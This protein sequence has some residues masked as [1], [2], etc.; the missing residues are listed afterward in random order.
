M[1]PTD[2][3]PESTVPIFAG[4]GGA[5]IG[6]LAAE[7][8][9]ARATAMAL[10]GA[11]AGAFVVPGVAEVAGITSVPVVS[12]LSALAGMLML[13]LARLLQSQVDTAGRRVLDALLRRAGVD[14][15]SRP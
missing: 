10:S 2:L 1:D 8:S 4:L 13:Q 6:A 11:L 14:G 5:V 7:V 9:P 12:S 3:M 15:G